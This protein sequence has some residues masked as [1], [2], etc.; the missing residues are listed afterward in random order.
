VVIILIATGIAVP[1]FR[2]TFKSAQMQDA[3]R[4]TV[5]M[6]RYARSLSILKQNDCTLQ[7]K[8]SQLLLSCGETNRSDTLSRRI[9]D[10]IKMSYF[11]N[12]AHPQRSPEED[13]M[14]RFYSNGM[15]EGFEL[16]LSD[17]DERRVTIDCD[18]ITGKTTVTEDDR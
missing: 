13:R 15:N 14:V 9:S 6:A 12:R 7:F 17:D 2:G 1:L 10:G 3:V 4:S 8:D 11:E 18:P 5:R 16:V